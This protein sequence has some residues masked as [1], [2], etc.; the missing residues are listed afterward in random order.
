MSTLNFP[1]SEIKKVKIEIVLKQRFGVL[2]LKLKQ[3]VFVFNT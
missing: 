1:N 2:M 3:L